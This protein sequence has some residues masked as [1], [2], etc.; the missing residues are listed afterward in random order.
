MFCAIHEG[1]VDFSGGIWDWAAEL[2]NIALTQIDVIA[3][4]LTRDNACFFMISGFISVRISTVYLSGLLVESYNS[5]EAIPT[6]AGYSTAL[7]K[8]CVLIF[9]RWWISK[10]IWWTI[11]NYWRVG[12]NWASVSVRLLKTY[13]KFSAIFFNK[14]FRCLA[15]WENKSRVALDRS[16]C[17]RE[18]FAALSFPSGLFA[19]VECFQGC[20]WNINNFWRSL[21]SFLAS[22]VHR[23]ILSIFQFLV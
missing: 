20:C 8:V 9:P 6:D 16:P 12:I 19:P 10:L 21:C 18:F 17:L 11:N 2:D 7:S 3:A 14:A 5:A 1:D 15:N 13:R 23:G 4:M 22:G